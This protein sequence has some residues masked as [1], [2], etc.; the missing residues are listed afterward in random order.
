MIK[1]IFQKAP[2]FF[3]LIFLSLQLNAQTCGFGCL[4]LSGIYGGYSRQYY[5]AVGLNLQLNDEL[6]NIGLTDQNFN[7]EYGEGY[8]FGAN[9]FR[10]KFD[11]YFLT[12]K[13]YFQYIKEQQ[14][15]REDIGGDVYEFNSELVMNYWGI[16]VDFGIPILSVLD[17]KIVEGNLSFYNTDLS[18]KTIKNGN[19]LIEDKYSNLEVTLGYYVGTGLII[20]ILPDYISLEG[21]AGYS[22]LKINELHSVD[23]KTQFPAKEY[24][25]NLINKGGFSA[26]IQLNIGVPI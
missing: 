10:A 25:T 22:F 1:N 24:D 20:H 18:N 19:I 11:N 2:L 8:R 23:G 17:W 9:I 15:I 21:S 6:D 16:G 4:G 26:M 3:L 7:F 5:E 14:N 13:G 12:F